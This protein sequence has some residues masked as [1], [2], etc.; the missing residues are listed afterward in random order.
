MARI[1]AMR[2][3][4]TALIAA[5]LLCGGPAAGWTGQEQPAAQKHQITPRHRV[6]QNGKQRPLQAHDHAYGKQ[7][8]YAHDHGQTESD[9]P[10]PGLSWAH[11]TETQP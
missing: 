11:S 10:R 9:T 1:R 8:R 4:A 6:V 7:Q 2:A 3:A 5:A